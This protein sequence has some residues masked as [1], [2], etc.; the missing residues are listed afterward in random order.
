MT[1]TFS[2]STPIDTQKNN[3]EYDRIKFENNISKRRTKSTK[4]WKDYTTSLP[5]E[6]KINGTQKPKEIESRTCDFNLKNKKYSDW[7]KESNIKSSDFNILFSAFAVLISRYT[8]E[9]NVYISYPITID[10]RDILYLGAVINTV[11][12]CFNINATQSFSDLLKQRNINFIGEIKNSKL[13]IYETL[14]STPVKKLN[15]SF[16]QTNLKNEAYN[17]E[18]CKTTVIKDT[19]LYDISGSDI[20]LEYETADNGDINFRIKYI[21]IY[22]NEF[23]RT[24]STNY[25]YLLKQCLTSSNLPLKNIQVCN[26]EEYQKVI[27]DWNKTETPY[28][29]DKTVHALFEEQVEKTPDNIAVVFEDTRLSYRELNNR[30]NQLA[31]AIRKEYKNHW[32]YEIKGDTLI[33]IY[34]DRSLEMII[35]ILGIL[36]A[37]A[38]YVPFDRAEPEERLKFKINDCGCKMI[39]TSSSMVEDLVFITEM[40]TLPISIDSYWSNISKAR[41]TNP[42]NINKSTDLAYAIYTSG[43]TGNP[44]GTMIEHKNLVN[45]IFTTINSHKQFNRSNYK[46]F[47]FTTFSF[48]IFGLE[49]F[50]TL[51]NSGSLYLQNAAIKTDTSKLV[52]NINKIL[53]D[54]I[55]GTPSFYSTFAYKLNKLNRTLFIVGG[56][57]LTPDIKNSLQEISEDIYNYYGP[58]ETT[59]WSTSYK[60]DTSKKIF[61][62][63][64]LR[65]QQCYILDQ[66]LKP[67][68][69]GIKGELYIGG[70]GLARGYLKRPDLTSNKFIN[71]PFQPKT[72][73]YKTGDLCRWLQDGS[74]EYIGRND[75]QI[76]INGL[77]IELGEIE[78]KICEYPE[79]KQCVVTV[80]NH[81]KTS[82]KTLVAYYTLKQTRDCRRETEDERLKTFLSEKLPDYMIPNIF[83]QLK[84]MPLNTSGKIDRKALPDPEFKSDAQTYA[85]PETELEKEFCK[86]WQNLLK[87]DRIGITD[88]FFR[89]GGNSILAIQL[90]HR[91]RK[92]LNVT[93]SVP[94]IFKYKTTKQLITNALGQERI[95]IPRTDLEKYPLSYAQKRLCFI[96]E[97][98]GGT[99][100]YNIPMILRLN[101]KININEL[102]SALTKLINR[103]DILRTIIKEDNSDYIQVIEHNTVDIKELKVKENT[104]P[105]VIRSC[106]K[107][108]F[109]LRE[110][111][112]IKI[113]IL[114]SNILI[115]NIHH[116]AFDGWSISIFINELKEIYLSGIEQRDPILPELQIQYRDFAVWQKEYL[117]GKILEEQVAFWKSSLEGYENINLPLDKQRPSDTSYAGDNITFTISK[118]LSEKARVIAKSKG[119]T[120][121]ALLLTCYKLFL[122]KHC[123]QADIVVGSPIA[124]R[125]YGKTENVIGFFVNTLALRTKIDDNENINELINKINKHLIDA[126]C[127][128]D[129]PFEKIV[130]VLKVKKD[131]SRSPI[132]QVMF[133]VQKSGYKPNEIFEPYPTENIYEISKFD[134]S[135]FIDDSKDK[136]SCNIEYAT[137][138]F[139]KDTAIRMS[140][141]FQRIVEQVVNNLNIQVKE[142]SLL[143][144][145][146]YQ[147]IVYD[148]N[149][150]ETPY[151]SDKTV[152]ALFEEQAERTPD[153]TALVFDNCEMTY[154][155]LNEKTNKL[156]NIIRKEYKEKTGTNLKSDTLI[157]ICVNRSFDMIIGI[158]GILKSGGV[159]VPIDPRYPVDRIKYILNDT[160][161]QI[162][163]T[164]THISEKITESNNSIK[165]I[166]LSK[167]DY[168]QINVSTFQP[169]S[170]STNLAYCLYTSGTTGKP[171]GVLVKHNSNVNKLYSMIQKVGIDLNDTYIFKTNYI[172]DVS[173]TDIFCHLLSGS[174]L[175]ITKNE[176]DI[177][178]ITDTIIQNKEKRIS[179]HFVPSQYW[180]VKDLILEN[181]IKNIYFSGEAL[182]QTI[183]NEI[184][185]NIEIYNFYGPTETGEV[186][187][188]DYRKSRKHTDIGQPFSNTLI[189]ILDNNMNPVPIGIIG[190]L[191][192]G[193]I[194]LAHGYLNKPKLTS[195]KFVHNPF[196]TESDLKK[197]YTRLYKSGDLC[198][199]LP[200]GNIEYIGRN[201][202]QVKI[203]G[204]RIE[205][206]EIESA[207][208][209]H[210]SIKQ[211]LIDVKEKNGNKYLIGY[212]IGDK[213]LNRNYL[214]EYLSSTLPDHMVPNIF[215]KL[216]NLPLTNTGKL[217]RRALPNPLL[218]SNKTYI[219]PET[220]REK[221]LCKIW[222]DLLDLDQ[223]GITDNFFS[224]SGNSILAI[225]LSHMMNKKLDVNISVSDIFR[226]N[227]I[228][229]IAKY[230]NTDIQEM[231]GEEI[232]L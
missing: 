218:A 17:L 92:E 2:K 137:S 18:N 14:N 59:I 73:M 102:K 45:F 122:S 156:A 216:E 27:Y 36:K 51:L 62:G 110:E 90:S 38:A 44:K 87:L 15:L 212:Y 165:Q 147:T 58:T 31:H 33:G 221:E 177:N 106:I 191:Y 186:T 54:I 77:R 208:L 223:V 182:T 16:A 174:R 6:L 133:G 66:Y 183:I 119:I 164:Q 80:F 159:Y 184:P 57:E 7:K 214:I 196:A 120:L 34:I 188:Q 42:P 146:E 172:F 128:Q 168:S 109:K 199:Y 210:T 126:Q 136:L 132:F 32:D 25:L 200:D 195:E 12:A 207:L 155:E 52:N 88:D 40:D 187:V 95:D 176:F 43:S 141:H 94:N 162:I 117:Q 50:G 26:P 86:I 204:F 111:L 161:A 152:H 107:T 213:T 68:S 35:A 150:T 9:E 194:Q 142:I 11:P 197:G 178:E 144:K 134:L 41:N 206:D 127:H 56:E 140:E 181:N 226:H 78:A 69:I 190:E 67:V 112:P 167:I 4:F 37:G 8:N 76:K 114:N 180:A 21:N 148:W 116:I 103:H 60:L 46:L 79:I 166:I 100:A 98:E 74:I 205:L 138:L 63:K 105:D 192:I 135:L 81:P 39:L 163:L 13:P 219:A 89:I 129:M 139:H 97:Y 228:K 93:L 170:A 209:K 160:N 64:P 124:N 118:E 91:I 65:N 131:L 230:L 104:I 70:E 84:K 23:I 24:L 55:Q 215:I 47:S 20:S 71:N 30:A 1:E 158:I 113:W 175:I 211:A 185:D 217:D 49:L 153:N 3:L 85:A 179:C 201:D 96:D 48:D 171:K 154:R 101:P 225:R 198:K 130:D 203:R 151:P 143:T 149:K 5:P 19:F 82:N 72:K 61:I 220:K 115:I 169:F 22:N 224:I 99:N 222:Q 83:I 10:K 75:F 231:E 202:F 121:Y 108:V 232:E 145:E 193:G 28:P 29:K 189:Y 227:T 123:G 173:F 125:H 157:P 229:Q 53:P